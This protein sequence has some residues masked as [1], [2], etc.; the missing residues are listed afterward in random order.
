VSI[1]RFSRII[2]KVPGLKG[3]LNPQRELTRGAVPNVEQYKKKADN[4]RNARRLIKEQRKQ[5]KE[6]RKQIKEQ[7]KAMRY[8]RQKILRQREQ[9]AKNNQEIFELKNELRVARQ[10]L[11]NVSKGR[12]APQLEVESKTGALPDRSPFFVPALMRVLL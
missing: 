1:S 6:Q 11:E 3:F 8:A 2:K 9:G 10:Q 5:I 7:A 4:L 12:T